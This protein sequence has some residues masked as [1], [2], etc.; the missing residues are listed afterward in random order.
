MSTIDKTWEDRL[1]DLFSQK[2]DLIWEEALK[3][4]FNDITVPRN[5][6]DS[7]LNEQLDLLSNIEQKRKR[8]S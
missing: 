6:Y 3:D 2:D 5:K 1:E 4:E 7:E 8:I